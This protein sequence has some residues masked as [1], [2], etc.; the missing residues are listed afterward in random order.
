MVQLTKEQLD[1]LHAAGE[2][3][4]VIEAEI[5]RAE[6]AGLDVTQL[7]AQLAQMKKSREALLAVYGGQ[8]RRRT[9]A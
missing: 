5:N 8:V 6:T 4:S 7:R 2:T 9:V 1:A 3:L